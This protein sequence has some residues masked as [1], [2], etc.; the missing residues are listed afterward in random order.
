MNLRKI[1]RVLSKLKILDCSV[2]RVDVLRKA[3][4]CKKEGLCLAIRHALV[5]YDLPSLTLADLS[6]IFPLFT[7]ENAKRFD[8]DPFHLYWWPIYEWN[9]GRMDFLNWLIEQYKNDNT[10]LRKL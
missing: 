3:K 8:G 2:T 5:Y 10:D 4:S 1:K 7:R 9:T 6:E